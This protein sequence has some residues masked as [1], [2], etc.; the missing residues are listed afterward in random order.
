[1]ENPV[2]RVSLATTVI[3]NTI[4]IPDPVSM[5]G[6]KEVPI[7]PSN[8]LLVNLNEL[9]EK[10]PLRVSSQ[11]YLQGIRGS[12]EKIYL[13]EE[14][15]TRLICASQ[16]LPKGYRLTLFDGYRSLEVQAALFDSFKT[17]LANQYPDTDE[18]KIIEM[19]QT[20]VSLPSANPT[21]PSP[22]ATGGAIDLSI[23]DQQGNLL[24][25]G[26]E[27]DSFEILAQTAYFKY[28]SEG[29]FYHLNRKF[30]HS[31]MIIAGFTNYPEEW[32]HYDYGNQ[33]WGHI[34]KRPAIYGLVRGGDIQL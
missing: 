28:R 12:S 7:E 26:T 3:D 32:W 5:I 14:A 9:E 33:F 8:Q 21:R 16:L 20:Y 24:D 1:M 25:M 6:W 17:L 13:R 22:H 10:Y 15:A 19:T 2:F 11:Y 23:S 29:L 4:D 34:L 18:E 27:F 30:L 31:I